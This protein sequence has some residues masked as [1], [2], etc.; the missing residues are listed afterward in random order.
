VEYEFLFVVDGVS[1]DD[2]DAVAILTDAFDGVL[3][4]NRGLYRLAVSSNGSNAVDALRRLLAGIAA[5]LPTLRILRVDPDLVG[6][7]DIAERTGHTR[8]NVQQWVSGERN[9]A[10]PFPPPEGCAGRSLIWR[11]A[12]VN[13]WLKPLGLDDQTMRPTREES[14]FL[15]VELV[16]LNNARGIGWVSGGEQLAG[17][18]WHGLI[19]SD[20]LVAHS[21]LESQ[22]FE[23]WWAAPGHGEPSIA[24]SSLS[25]SH[26][27]IVARI[28]VV[29]GRELD[30]WFRR[31]ESAPRFLQQ[32]ERVRWLA[33]DGGISYGY[34]D[35][36]VC[37]Y[38]RRRRIHTTEQHSSKTPQSE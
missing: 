26:L 32:E 7:S 8:Q 23:D 5:R 14:V 30:D 31:L 6:V 34:A 2:D 24:Q 17:A 12:D 20:R 1:M 25:P 10:R 22:S 9:A 4:S 33:D 35:A 18:G 37:E 11:W 28:P 27:A 21:D 29:T 38:D 3:S 15:D 19:H 36:V 13:D 16:K